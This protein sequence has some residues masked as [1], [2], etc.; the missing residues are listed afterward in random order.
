MKLDLSGINDYFKSFKD[1]DA[2]NQAKLL[3]PIETIIQESFKIR[4]ADDR[5]EELRRRYKQTLAPK[6]SENKT[7]KLAKVKKMAIKQQ[8]EQQ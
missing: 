6:P 3:P 2:G 7:K 8:I 1:E 5:F 4:I